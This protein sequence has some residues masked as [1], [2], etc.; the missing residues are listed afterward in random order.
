VP[1]L[2]GSRSRVENPG[3]QWHIAGNMRVVLDTNVLVAAFRSARG[4]SR[5]I[6][7]AALQGRFDLL[8]SVPLAL[9]Y[10]E[11]LTRAKHLSIFRLS[12]DDVRRVLGFLF[13]ICEAV[14]IVYLWRPHLRDPEDEMVLE[15]AIN[16][17]ADCLVTFNERD[18]AAAASLDV[19][20]LS[21]SAF[22]A[23]M[24]ER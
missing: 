3:G 13:S 16:G 17:R 21:P 2:A 5:V 11:V 12:E 23:R 19:Q 24:Q 4:A 6:V 1:V 15:A 22:L 8:V 7:E 20:I 14:E 10:E 9:Q 18:F